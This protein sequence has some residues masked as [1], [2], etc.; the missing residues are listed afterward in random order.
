MPVLPEKISISKGLRF[1][2]LTDDEAA[3]LIKNGE[4]VGFSGFTAAGTPKVVPQAI[5][6][7]AT[8]EHAEGRPFQIGVVT[9]ASTGPSLDG[10]LARAD[11]IAFRTPYQSDPDLRQRINAGKTNFFDMHLSMLPQNVRYGF[12]G[13]FAW[14]VMQACEVTNDG[15]IILTSSVGAAP[16]FCRVADRIIIELNRYHPNRLRGFHDIYEPLDPPHRREIPVYQPSSRIGT[17]FIQVDPAKIAGIVETN[18][19]DETI[20]FAPPAPVTTQIGE[21]VAGFLAEEL[22]RGSIP[23]PFLPI[24]SGVGDIAN[25]VLGA[26]GSHRGIPNFEMFTEVIQDSV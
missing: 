9:G 1:P 13:K 12:L 3:S 15:Q 18:L 10:S 11:A 20:G 25:A 7:R 24:Q 4:T 14:A 5:A 26:M 8:K 21:N 22:R 16:T 23:K 6:R 19:A 17:P 2:V